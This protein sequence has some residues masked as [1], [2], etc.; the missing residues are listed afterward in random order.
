MLL[1]LS[2]RSA[3]PNC[4]QNASIDNRSVMGQFALHLTAIKRGIRAD[5][6]K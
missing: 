3:V 5:G 6:I 4:W 1:K 2:V